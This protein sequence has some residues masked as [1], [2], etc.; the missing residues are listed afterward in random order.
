MQLLDAY[1][2]HEKEETSVKR[3]LPHLSGGQGVNR[4]LSHLSDGREFLHEFFPK[5]VGLYDYIRQLSERFIEV[6]VCCGD[7]LRIVQPAVTLAGKE[8]TSNGSAAIFFDPP[9]SIEANRS[10]VYS[11][12]DFSV[13][14]AVR[15]WCIEQTDNPKMRIALAGYD[16]EHK[17]LEDHGWTTLK[18]SANGGYSVIADKGNQ[19]HLNKHREVVWFSPSC[20]GSNEMPLFG[21]LI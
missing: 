4:Q 14:H 8:S 13:A 17:E 3:Q 21:D 16:V 9:Y 12:E 11:V 15:T 18:W 19:S 2:E 20:I 7:W 6:D 10:S 1:R 5:N